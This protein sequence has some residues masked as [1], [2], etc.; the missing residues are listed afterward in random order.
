MAS[1]CSGTRCDSLGEAMERLISA[2]SHVTVRHEDVKAKLPVRLHAEYDDAVAKLAQTMR[3]GAGQANQA[4][5]REYDHPAYGRAGASDPVERLKDMDTDGVEAEV[6]YCEVSAFRYLYLLENGWRDSTP[7]RGVMVPMTAFCTAEAFGMWILGG[8]LERFPELKLVFVE[9]GV[10]WVAW[11]LYIIDDMA[12]R[13]KYQ[14]PA[15]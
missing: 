8:V 14:F 15:I 4:M 13:Q 5:M 7:Q 6:L 12:T 3:R 11:Y 10:G 2:D 9:P 1:A